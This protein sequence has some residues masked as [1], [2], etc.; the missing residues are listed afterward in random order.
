MKDL[1]YLEKYRVLFK[2]GINGDKHNGM[3]RFKVKGSP[4]EVIASDGMG[5]DHVS[6]VMFN[7]I[8]DWE[9]MCKVNEM[10]F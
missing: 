6:V 7:R 3:F 4:V 5:W 1:S 8:P 9:T 2:D 10:F